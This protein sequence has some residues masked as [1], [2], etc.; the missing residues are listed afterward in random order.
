MRFVKLLL[1]LFITAALIWSL[2]RSWEAGGTRIPPL[3][4]FL[5]PFHGFWQNLESRHHIFAEKISIPGLKQPVTVVFDSLMIPHLY[6]QNEEDLYAAQGYVTAMQR[7]WQM[8]F[9]THAAAGRVSEI[10]GAGKDD[11]VLNYDRGQRRLGMVYAAQNALRLMQTRPEARQV[12]N[13]YTDGINAYITSL[14]YKDLPLEYKLLDY[15]PELWSPLKCALL[16]KNMAQTLNSGDKDMQM[17]NALKLFGP[18]LIDVLYPD[19]E[20]VGDPIVEKPGGWKFEHVPLTDVPLAVPDELIKISGLTTPDPTIGSNNWAVSGSKTKSGAPILCNDPHLSTTLP[21]IWYVIQL[22]AP[23]VNTMGA[24]LP[25]A[26]GVISGWNDSIAWGVTNAQRD[27]VDWYAVHFDNLSM[28]RFLLDGEWIDSR[29]IIETFRVR[30]GTPFNDTVTYTYWGPVVYDDSYRSEN[31][32]K[33]FAYRWAA[34]DESEELMTF[35]ELNRARNHDDYMKALDHFSSPAQNFVFASVS[36][37]IA[38]RIQ[39]KFPVRRRQEGK[40]ILDGSKTASG[41]KAFIPFEQNVMDKN[42]E[43][44]FVS[45][46]NQYPVDETYPYYVHAVSYEAYRNRRIN[47]VLRESSG[48]TIVDM[49]QLQNDNYSIKAEESLP[50]MLEQLDAGKLSAE[51]KAAYDALKQWDYFFT[52]ESVAA[53]YYEAWFTNLMVL[54]WDEMRRDD[55]SLSTPTAWNTINLMKTQPDLS[56]Y[57]RTDTPEKE[58]LQDIV[59]LAFQTGVADVE[60]WKKVN[61]EQ[62]REPAWAEYKDTYVEHLL[63]LEPLGIH[64]SHGGHGN[65]VNA[66]SRKHGPSWRMIVSLEKTGPV[67]YATY[68][69]GQSGNPGSFHYS[70]MLGHWSNGRY[71]KL[72][73]AATPEAT[74]QHRYATTTLTPKP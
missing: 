42:P 11:A 69:G 48:I 2:D 62:P 46:A 57:D 3:G 33:Y 24:S 65:A 18:E 64:V 36:G 54:I 55:L 45:S 29:K 16:L 14:R 60:N 1:S 17:T 71:F 31:N 38:M 66:S 9:Q 39:G 4:K 73:F 27:L 47:N 34:H 49:M 6:A 12:V 21:S 19:R 26:P 20:P 74:S 37:D 67:P 59:Q 28:N 56:F 68:P 41:W 32:R 10:I 44:G 13:S 72:M 35:Y 30:G 50:Y 5:D 61:P 52:K 25:G 22:N 58:S 70:S 51:E 53:S 23:G 40:F 8:E 43:R 7:L 15:T 63:R